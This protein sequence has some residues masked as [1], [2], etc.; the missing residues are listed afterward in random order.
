MTYN[1]KSLPEQILVITGATSGHG[2]ATARMAADAGARLI[3]VSRDEEAL[4]EVRDDLRDRGAEVE[5]KVADVGDEDQIQAVADFAVERFGGFDTWI[6][7]AGVGVYGKALEVSTEDHE[8]VFRT[9]YWGVVNGSLAAVRHL[10]DRP[11]GGALINVGS[12]N[13]DM[14]SGL[15]SAYNASKHA[16]KGFTDSLRIELM[17]ETAPVSVTL[18]K[19]S[20]IGT[21]FPRHGRNITGAKAQL[22]Q[23]IYAPELVAK[24]ILHAAQ[25][26]R[27]AITVGGAGRFQVFGATVF[28]PLFDRIASRM[29]G[30]LIDQDQPVGDVDGALHQPVGDD[31]SVA[32]EQKGRRFS[33][34]TAAQLRPGLTAGVVAGLGLSAAAIGWAVTDR[35][36][37]V[38]RL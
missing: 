38:S 31:A 18:I 34:Y 25:T 1:L 16:V 6:N 19:P 26:P 17:R 37:S 4:R 14:P 23:P 29:T 24:A 28:P 15:L 2:L 36:R 12:V 13:S 5:Y 10:K 7:N 22:P 35:M 3:I 9:N 32:G 21:P 11:G 8:R 27:R 33:L 30:A 20:A